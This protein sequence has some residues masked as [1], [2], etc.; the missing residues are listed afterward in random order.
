MPLDREFFFGQPRTMARAWR[1][2]MRAT[3]S[4]PRCKVC[5]APYGGIGGRAVRLVG[6]G[7]SRKN[8]TMCSTCFEK[9]PPGGEEM[10][11][12]V[13]FADVR[14]F[15]TMSESIEPR[16]ASEY[17]NRFYETATDVLIAR[18]ALI[19]KLVGDEVM[20]LFIPYFIG[21]HHVEAMVKAAFDL[22]RGVG[23]GSP[24]GPWCPIGVGIDSGNAFVGNVGP[25]EIK[26]FTAVGDVVNTASRLQG[27]ARPG[28]IVV[29]ER[30][31]SSLA[32]PLDAAPSAVVVAGKAEPVAVRIMSC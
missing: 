6:F 20:A 23:R 1:R 26:D 14:G 7:P 15:T 29:S 32:E 12:G 5:F 27:I 19:D 22:Q 28:Q 4:D 21:A 30:A 31:Y 16:A 10:D 24:E 9:A 11:I 3:P 17:L 13:F 18:G 25:G 2:V 8:P